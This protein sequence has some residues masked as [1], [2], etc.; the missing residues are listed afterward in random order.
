MLS[1]P[2]AALILFRRDFLVWTGEPVWLAMATLTA[3]AVAATA[4]RLFN[5]EALLRISPHGVE[6]PHLLCAPIPWRDIGR[7]QATTRR[8]GVGEIHDRLIFHFKHA[9][10]VDWR[11]SKLR[12]LFGDTPQAAVAVDIGLTWP[13]RADEAK[14]VLHN[15]VRLYAGA[16]D[17]ASPTKG[18]TPGRRLKT[19]AVVLAAALLPTMAHVIDVG[20]PRQFSEALAL[21]REGKIP[22]AIPLLE[23]DARAGDREAA[24]VLGTLY[25]NGDG[26]IR[27]PA[28]AAGWLR[29][30]AEAGHTSAAFNLGN[31]YRL[32][33]G[34]PQNIAT[35]MNW[36]ERAANGGSAEA[37]Y[38]LGTMLRLGDQVR[39]DYNRA[40][41]WLEIAAERYYAP[42]EHDLG[43][44]Y[45]EGIA[46]PRDLKTATDW[47]SRAAARGHAPARYDLA[48]LMLDGN[49]QQ[50]GIGLKY[51]AQ[52]ADA[53]FAPAQRRLAA[54]YFGAQGVPQSAVTAFKWISLAERA[55][56]A[57]TRAD[58][59]REKARIAAA[60]SP[61]EQEEAMALIRA[62]RPV[63]R[64]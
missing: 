13:L 56:P 24:F 23:H 14:R 40:I 17:V 51:L 49:E 52:S 34:T 38:T 12:R 48:R 8:S 3:I 26:V 64:N 45:Q 39:R 55:W 31:A 46:V 43:R 9:Q 10:T 60:L 47:Y 1:V 6:I 63:R 44:L 20:M 42:A 4:R 19:V 62:W 30:A 22:A 41:V 16:P 2:L 21:Y 28:M 32:G 29:R 5:P 36:Y 53:G 25:L 33:L 54:V 11:P 18:N 15:A 7:I 50:R 58:L 59:V 61:G 57:A 27:N 35:A 37:A